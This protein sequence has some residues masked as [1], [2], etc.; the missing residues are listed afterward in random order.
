MP[1]RSFPADA[2]DETVLIDAHADAWFDGAGDN[3]DGLAVMLG[4][5]RHFAKPE[6]IAPSGPWC[7]LS[8]PA[9]TPRASTVHAASSRPIPSSRSRR[10]VDAEHRARRPAQLL[11][12]AHRRSTDGYRQAMADSGEAPTY[13]GISNNAPFLNALFQQGVAEYGVNFV[14]ETSDM[15]EWGNRRLHRAEGGA[16]DRDAGAAALSHDGRGARRD[17][18]ARSGAHGALSRALH[19]RDGIGPARP[20]RPAAVN[21]RVP[22]ARAT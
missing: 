2:P 20:A 12:G 17:L 5:A 19:S 15:A 3:A 14:S 8:V 10:G 9:T 13:A 21:H 22:G 7:S 6:N 18:D 16:G 11:P 4:L 1:S